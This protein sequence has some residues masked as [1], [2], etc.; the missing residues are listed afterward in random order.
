MADM[1]FINYRRALAGAAAIAALLLIG[2]GGYVF[3]EHIVEQGVQRAELKFEEERKGAEAEANRKVMEAANKADQERQAKAAQEAEQIR[4][5]DEAEQQRLAAVKAEQERQAKAAQQAAASQARPQPAPPTAPTTGV[6]PRS[7]D[8]GAAGGRAGLAGA[9]APGSAP[10]PNRPP[11][12]QAPALPKAPESAPAPSGTPT[13]P[14]IAQAPA[15]PKS[16]PAPSGAPTSP[17]LAQAPIRPAPT[18]PPSPSSTGPLTGRDHPDDDARQ[19]PAPNGGPNS[20]LEKLKIQRRIEEAESQAL[21][22]IKPSDQLEV[23]RLKEQLEQLKAKSAARTDEVQPS[24]LPEFPWPPPAASASYVLPDNLLQG[25]RTVGEVAAAIISAL[26]HNGYVERS[27]FRTNAGGVALVTRLERINNDGTSVLGI[28]RWSAGQAIDSGSSASL[29]KFLSGLFFVPAGR[30]RVIVFVLQDLSFSQS[31]RMIGEVEATA[32][33]SS[34]FNFLPPSIANRPFAPD[35]HCTVLVYEFA[36]DGKAVHEI[37]SGLTGKQHLEK[38]GVL[39]LL[40][41]VN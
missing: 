24:D 23:E 41:N 25:R 39:S 3:A 13:R 35:G 16:A 40:G 17:S 1:I 38:A 9:G 29:I 31:S 7:G 12:A 20:E 8:S 2:V 19:P 37:T 6:G 10:I 32:W 33:L 4:K 30:Y 5:A 21:N 27:F 14:P 18:Q 22:N 15:L 34:G 36:S 28:E 11:I 26:E